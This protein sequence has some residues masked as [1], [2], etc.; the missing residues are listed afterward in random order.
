MIEPTPIPMNAARLHD[1]QDEHE[2]LQ[3]A[4]RRE[5]AELADGYE[6]GDPRETE[7]RVLEIRLRQVEGLLRRA[8]VA[9]P[10]GGLAETITLGHTVTLRI[11]EEVAT[12]TIVSP[13]EARPREG[14]ISHESPVG[15][16]LLGHRVGDC[17]TIAV[18]VGPAMQA[19]IEAITI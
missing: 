8:K 10:E 13:V 16:A 9:T 12:Y 2:R 7:L 15:R 17:C 19:R 1:L 6:P 3:A 4:Q 18:P 14:R 5:R 11:D